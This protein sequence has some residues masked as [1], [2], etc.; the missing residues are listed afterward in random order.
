[1]ARPITGEDLSERE[2]S[3]LKDVIHTYVLTGEP[4]SSRTVSKHAQHGLSAASIRNVMA[5]LEDMDLLCQPHTSAG[6]VPTEAAYRLYVQALMTRSSLSPQDKHYIEDRLREAGDAEQTMAAITHLLSEL[7][8]QVGVVLTPVVDEIFLKSADFVPIGRRKVL[9]VLVSTS[10]FIDNVTVRTDEEVTRDDL[11][12][13]S[14]YVTESFSGKRLR[15]IREDLLRRMASEKSDVDRWLTGALRLAQQ[16]LHGSA[17]QEVLLEGASSLLGRPELSDVERVR[18][19]LD[20]FADQA[21]LVNLLSRCL[22]SEGGV[23]V[24][25]GEDSDVTSELEFSM[26]ATTYGS[27]DGALGSLGVI[28]PSRME[29]PRM[30]PLVR[31]LGKTLSR[32]LS[33]AESGRRLP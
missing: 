7:S 10:G 9:C 3:I 30:V 32:A 17:E 23:R 15:R 20:T 6:R 31:H 2:Q 4:V 18:R 28:G 19:M 22:E 27:G 21:R 13:M 16:A 29:Y 1:M 24:F 26:V 25:I 11:V 5:D 33:Q 12:R 8:D 14:N